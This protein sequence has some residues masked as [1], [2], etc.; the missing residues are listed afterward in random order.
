MDQTPYTFHNDSV[1]D[2][3]FSPVDA[4][5]MASCSVDGTLKLCDLRDNNRKKA[6][7]SI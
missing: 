3:E 4:W 6:H 7:T 1:E 2:V 5:E